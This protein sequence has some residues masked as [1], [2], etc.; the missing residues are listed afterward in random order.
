MYQCKFFLDEITECQKGQIRKSFQSSIK[1]DKYSLKKWVLCL[2]KI[3][4]ID[5]QGWWDAWKAKN[6]KGELFKITSEIIAKLKKNSNIDKLKLDKLEL[7]KIFL[8]KEFDEKLKKLSFSEENIILISEL[9]KKNY[10]ITI[11]LFN[12][13]TLIGLLKKFHLYEYVFDI[14]PL[15]ILR[16]LQ[17]EQ[18][19]R[20]ASIEKEIFEPKDDI[21]YSSFMYQT[22]LKTAN[23]NDEDTLSICKRHYYNAEI[24]KKEIDNRDFKEEK[25][26]YETLKNN[27]YDLWSTE[28]ISYPETKN[29]GNDLLAEVY[30]KI[31]IK[32]ET[33]LTQIA[34]A[35]LASKKGILHQLS[36]E[37]KVGWVKKFKEKAKNMEKN[38]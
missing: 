31:E 5:E 9:S 15:K 28:Y 2:P 37:C 22:K 21:D 13:T 27:I 16:E 38:K 8:K 19:E 11:E 35:S 12:E 24:L 29:D 32:N 10:N 14:E 18:S 20:R 17:K 4:D 33:L 26:N 1:S 23:I 7:N 25:K 6:S 36:D 30:R 3:L 34:N